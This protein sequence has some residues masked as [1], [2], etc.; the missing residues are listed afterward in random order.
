MRLSTWLF[1]VVVLGTAMAIARDDMGRVA[2]IAFVTGVAVIA[3]V[4]TA[5]MA[6][7]QTVAALSEAGTLTAQVEAIAATAVVLAIGSSASLGLL[8]AGAVLVAWSVP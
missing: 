3:T 8:Y 7:F 6:L 4:L 2:L 1:L 5:V